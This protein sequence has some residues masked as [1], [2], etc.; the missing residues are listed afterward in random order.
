MR[1]AALSLTTLILGVGC[2]SPTTF[3]TDRDVTL[4]VEDAVA[5][6]TPTATVRAT[7]HYSIAN[8]G[9]QKVWSN[10]LCGGA[11]LTRVGGAVIDLALPCVTRPPDEIAPGD[12]LENAITVE[13]AGEV[14]GPTVTGEYVLTLAVF[15]EGRSRA[16]SIHSAPF[17]IELQDD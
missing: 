14:W 9:N 7:L 13:R 12:T 4:S 16:E 1:N 11:L 10:G 2:S 5:T 15:V 3:V 6:T 17:V 8:D